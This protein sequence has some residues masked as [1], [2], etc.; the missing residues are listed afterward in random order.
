MNALEARLQY[1]ISLGILGDSPDAVVLG[2]D[3]Q[4]VERAGAF[5]DEAYVAY[6]QAEDQALLVELLEIEE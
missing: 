6:V 4:A 1:M 3:K 2:G 5:C